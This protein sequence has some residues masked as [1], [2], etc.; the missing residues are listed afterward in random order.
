M[1]FVLN[2]TFLPHKLKIACHHTPTPNKIVGLEMTLISKMKHITFSPLFYKCF[3][4]SRVA[5]G[6]F[7]GLRSKAK[8]SKFY[9]WGSL[10]GMGLSL[11]KRVPGRRSCHLSSDLVTERKYL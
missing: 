9:C 1:T 6:I 5:F 2:V 3:I 8:I 10:Y 7:C 11:L 4:Y